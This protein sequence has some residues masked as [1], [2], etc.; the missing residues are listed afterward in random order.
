MSS[1]L[2]WAINPI[3]N[4][5]PHWESHS[6]T[7]QPASEV[8]W[9]RDRSKKL[10]RHKMEMEEMMAGLLGIIKSEIRTN[11]ANLRQMV[12]SQELLKQ[13]MLAKMETNKERIEANQE[14]LDAKLDAHHERMMVRMNYHLE[15]MEAMVDVFEER[16][17]KIE[18]MDLE[19]NPEQSRR[20][21]LK[22][23]LQSK[24]SRAL[25][26]WYVDHH[27]A[28][29]RC[30]QLEKLT[31]GDGG[32]QKKSVAAHRG[33]TRCALPALCKGHGRQGAPKER[34]SG[35]RRRAQPECVNGVWD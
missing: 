2:K 28:I 29:G 19:G 15:K 5:K 6:H 9:I 1:V 17:K 16:F 20:R 23:G 27:L 34:T 18:D 3:F 25:K 8:G 4:Q 12:A 24:L 32:S 14:K 35:K 10:Y 11:H 13:E 21:S 33:M 31:Q 22:K 7:S 30:R 26:K